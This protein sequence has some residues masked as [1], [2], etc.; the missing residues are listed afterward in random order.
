M[1]VLTSVSNVVRY[2]EP[3]DTFSLRLTDATGCEVLI[4]EEITV[5]ATIDFIA[6]YRFARD[7]GSCVAFHL[8]GIFGN[9]A[10]LPEEFATAV[11]FEDL[12]PEQQGRFVL[13]VGIRMPTK[14]PAAPPVE[15][16]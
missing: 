14:V 16:A 11:R 6:S 7:D 5:K 8:C 4:S 2:V 3:G 1:I 12:T 13:S 9:K 15:V 10:C